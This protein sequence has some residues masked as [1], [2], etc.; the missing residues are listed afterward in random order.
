MRDTQDKLT[1]ALLNLLIF[2]VDAIVDFYTSCAR[3]STTEDQINPYLKDV[4]VHSGVGSTDRKERDTMVVCEG[5]NRLIR[6]KVQVVVVLVTLLRHVSLFQSCG[7]DAQ[8][9][10]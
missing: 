10:V 3:I 4:M 9:S 6:I 7:V 8:G 2:R 1:P 5:L